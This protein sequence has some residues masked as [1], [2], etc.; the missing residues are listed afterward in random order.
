MK[1]LQERNFKLICTQ[2]SLSIQNFKLINL[3]MKPS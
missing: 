1:A 2:K 3:T